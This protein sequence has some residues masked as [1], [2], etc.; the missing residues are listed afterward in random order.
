MCAVGDERL[1]AAT[2]ERVSLLI[3]PTTFEFQGKI[4]RTGAEL[5][6][7]LHEVR[8]AMIVVR[9]DAGVKYEQVG[10][11]MEVIQRIGGIDIG[12]VGNERR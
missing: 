2:A 6:A 11:V 9:A 4:V 8:P 1:P 7:R 3:H 5:E 12:L 10:T